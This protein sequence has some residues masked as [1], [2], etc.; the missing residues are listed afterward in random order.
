MEQ[1]ILHDYELIE[2]EN[3]PEWMAVYFDFENA[4]A[5]DHRKSIEEA[6]DEGIINKQDLL[7]IAGNH[8]VNSQRWAVVSKVFYKRFGRDYFRE[9]YDITVRDDEE[10]PLQWHMTTLTQRLIMHHNHDKVARFEWLDDGTARV[11]VEQKE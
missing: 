5:S 6:F 10:Y 11:Y 4:R 3:M 2:E 1:G 7:A 8:T 9:E